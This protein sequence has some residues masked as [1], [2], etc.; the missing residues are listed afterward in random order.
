MKAIIAAWLFVWSLLLISGCKTAD[1]EDYLDYYRVANNA[2]EA[3]LKRDFE[4]AATLYQ[5]AFYIKLPPAESHQNDYARA[6]IAQL[7]LGNGDAAVEYLRK[8]MKRGYKIEAFRE[9]KEFVELLKISPGKALLNEFDIHHDEF[10]S[11]LDSDLAIKIERMKVLDQQYRTRLQLQIAD[12]SLADS[13]KNAGHFFSGQVDFERYPKMTDEERQQLV[14]LQ[15]ENDRRN[16]QEMEAIIAEHGYP[17]YSLIGSNDAAAILLHV[18]DIDN[19]PE[20]FIERNKI[21]DEIRKGTINPSLVA[22]IVDRISMNVNGVSK[23]HSGINLR[24]NIPEFD[25]A[26]VDSLRVGIG[27]YSLAVKKILDEQYMARFNSQK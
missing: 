26:E 14:H 5:K 1:S 24:S 6:A 23:Y 17:G 4:S 8:A 15:R 12:S 2:Y 13:L 10:R 3:F 19:D 22:S 20:A 11:G 7:Y 25:E 9:N 27:L 16:L 21:M 18:Q